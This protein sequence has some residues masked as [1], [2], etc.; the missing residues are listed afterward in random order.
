[1]RVAQ[2][3]VKVSSETEPSAPAYRMVASIAIRGGEALDVTLCC[4]R[5][6]AEQLAAGVS[7]R[8]PEEIDDELVEDGMGEFLNV[9]A[10]NA[11]SILEREGMEVSLEPPRPGGAPGGQRFELVSTT[12]AGALFL[13][14]RSG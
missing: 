3:A 4:D 12:G 13:N 8:Q 10:G 11:V 14:R 2:L 6:F 9:L 5:A 1:M 7:G